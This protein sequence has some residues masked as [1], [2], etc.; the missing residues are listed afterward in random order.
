M[1]WDRLNVM[2]SHRCAYCEASLQD[3]SGRTEGHIEHF[4]Q[5]SRY[6]Q[7]TFDWG[8]LFGS[9][10]RHQSCGKHKDRQKYDHPDL[11]K[12]D[13]EDP[14][15]FFRF[16]SDGL[17]VPTDHLSPSERRRAEETIRVF[18]LNGPLRQIRKSH[19]VGYMQT[20]EVIC[21]LAQ[22]FEESEWRTLLDQELDAISGQPFE[23]AIRHMLRIA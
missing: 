2:Q 10:D 12:V 9:C 23:T 17:V 5:R 3:K 15:H 11:I 6:P 13:E 20:A 7:G 16:L 19:V 18:N 4:R 21:H 14:E 22:E 8:N 1:I